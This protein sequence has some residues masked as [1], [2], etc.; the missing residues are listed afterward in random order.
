MDVV[1]EK[2]DVVK[3]G[4]IYIYIYPKK[5][6]HFTLH[7]PTVT[8]NYRV[9]WLNMAERNEETRKHTYGQPS[10]NDHGTRMYIYTYICIHHNLQEKV[11][12]R[13]S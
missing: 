10:H 4:Y 2:L 3:N 9:Q 1:T 12:H 11:Y 8:K 13:L 7:I 6:A 5:K